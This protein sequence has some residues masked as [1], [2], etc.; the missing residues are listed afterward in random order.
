MAQGQSTAN[1]FRFTPVRQSIT[2]S[3]IIQRGLEAEQELYGGPGP[4]TPELPQD[5]AQIEGIT[6]DVMN[7]WMDAKNFANTMWH[8]YRI[9]VTKPDSRNPLS[10]QANQAY[11]KA[12][13]SI[14][15]AG[16]KLKDY[17]SRLGKMDQ[18]IAEGY[19]QYVQDPRSQYFED[20][21]QFYASDKQ[22]P[23]AMQVNQY[24]A[25]GTPDRAA[26]KG[27]TAFINARIAELQKKRDAAARVGNVGL[28][29][30]IQNDIDQYGRAYYEQEQ[31]R[32]YDDKKGSGFTDSDAMTV[33]DEL[34]DLRKAIY[35]NDEASF[36]RLK[37]ANPNILYVRPTYG[38]EG[39]T[40]AIIGFK[41]GDATNEVRVAIR[42]N[43]SPTAGY[44][45]LNDI[46]QKLNPAKYKITSNQ[47]NPYIKRALSDGTAD[48]PEDQTYDEIQKNY[49]IFQNMF[50]DGDT[51]ISLPSGGKGRVLEAQK[52]ELVA[53]MNR[54]ANR[55]KLEL[56]N[57]EI[58][59][60]VKWEDGVLSFYDSEDDENPEVLDPQ[61]E[62]DLKYFM[63][64][65]DR[66]SVHFLR[67][68]EVK[69]D[70]NKNPYGQEVIGT[71]VDENIELAPKNET[72]KPFDAK[73][74]L[75][76]RGIE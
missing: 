47:L 38:G 10:V 67:R 32:P 50:D 6:S 13:A 17:N 52:K 66:N 31:F 74:F 48:L 71:K 72:K 45:E 40:G 18:A 35:Y 34:T 62:E 4:Q 29:Q 33:V 60:I 30:T 69:K 44:A 41:S 27:N 20:P 8:N 26:A 46:M 56:P 1:T 12:I 15:Y 28:A 76:S 73:A 7:Q 75:R 59:K 54:L 43:E 42:K 53:R 64:I 37:L 63:E 55:G 65:L 19:G 58:P 22:S 5:M 57:G 11:M 21:N 51:N 25:G 61:N 70:P 68:A 16:Q 2:P 9:D 39:R 49:T 24:V 14:Q 23:A 3:N 36:N